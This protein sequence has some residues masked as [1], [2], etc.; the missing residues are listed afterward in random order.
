MQNKYTNISKIHHQLSNNHEG[1]Q[2]TF[3]VIIWF[4]VYMDLTNVHGQFENILVLVEKVEIEGFLRELLFFRLAPKVASFSLW[5]M[6]ENI[7]HIDIPVRVQMWN[8]ICRDYSQSDCKNFQITLIKLVY[9]VCIIYEN[10]NNCVHC[11]FY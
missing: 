1:N 8:Y 5:L 3:F 10:S 7:W 6:V 9:L 4:M 2:T 11:F